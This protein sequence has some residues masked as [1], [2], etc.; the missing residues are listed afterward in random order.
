MRWLDEHSEWKLFFG[1]VPALLSVVTVEL[2]V[3]PEVVELLI[4][5]LVQG[6]DAQPQF[7][8]GM[9]MMSALTAGYVALC[10]VL[11][12]YYCNGVA[13]SA[14]PTNRKRQVAVAGIAT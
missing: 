8:Q 13:T 12:A 2:L 9:I 4:G 6:V 5:R 10:L 14:L 11:L 7:A 3:G 1:M